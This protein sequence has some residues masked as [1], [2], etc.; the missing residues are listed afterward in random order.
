MKAILFSIGLLLCF[1][2]V[3]GIEVSTN[4]GG[5]FWLGILYSLI[6][7]YIIWKIKE[8]NKNKRIH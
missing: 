7:V 1:A 3:G 2:G 6:G 4:F 5:Q 8:P